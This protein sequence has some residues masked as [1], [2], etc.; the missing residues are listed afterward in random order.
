M[1]R[2]LS[3]QARM[4]AE[5]H[6]GG[7]RPGGS[8]RVAAQVGAAPEPRPTPSVAERMFESPFVAGRRFS[9]HQC[10]GTPTSALVAYA[11]LGENV[12]ETSAAIGIRP[13]E[14]G[15]RGVIR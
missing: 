10:F 12:L 11:L 15:Q 5:R 14:R 7:P 4:Q 8:R 13:L 9:R 1:A 2:Y 3:C 6:T